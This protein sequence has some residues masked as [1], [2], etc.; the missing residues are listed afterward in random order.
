M[1]SSFVEP[2]NASS[3]EFAPSLAGMQGSKRARVHFGPVEIFSGT[4]YEDG[5]VDDRPLKWKSRRRGKKSV[6][7][8]DAA[9]LKKDFGFGSWDEGDWSAARGYKGFARRARNVRVRVRRFLSCF[10]SGW[11]SA[12]GE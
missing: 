9:L 3:S 1:A 2:R 5:D 12:I 4:K 6:V 10:R 8:E 11:S 7:S